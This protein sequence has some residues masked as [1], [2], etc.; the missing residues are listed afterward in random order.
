[1]PTKPPGRRGLSRRPASCP[2]DPRCPLRG[3]GASPRR[4]LRPPG[5]LV[6]LE[7]PIAQAL[8][9]RV[10]GVVRGA[11]DGKELHGNPP[12]L[13]EA[14]EVAVA[15]IER[16]E[17]AGDDAELCAVADLRGVLLGEGPRAIL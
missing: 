17:G 10:V 16:V 4:G 6:E 8:V 3:R 13:Q 12:L 14:G 1:M 2:R 7:G 5:V 9:E 15:S 11:L